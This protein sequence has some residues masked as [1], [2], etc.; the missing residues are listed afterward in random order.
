MSKLS[1]NQ[2]FDLIL[3]DWNMPNMNG[4][5]F[6]KSV[7]ASDQKSVPII[8][9]TTE[10]EKAKDALNGQDF[11]GRTLRIDEARP[12]REQS[13]GGGGGGYRRY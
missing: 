11:K 1:E 5:E 8:M 6:I 2:D 3:T 7:Q 9:I 12:R 13:R 10:A 4:L